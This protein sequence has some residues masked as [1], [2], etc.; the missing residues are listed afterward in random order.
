L[1]VCWP[2]LIMHHADWRNCQSIH[3][4]WVYSFAHIMPTDESADFIDRK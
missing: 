1:W 3:R 4:M 2:S